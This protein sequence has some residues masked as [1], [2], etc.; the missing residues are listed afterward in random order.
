MGPDRRSTRIAVLGAGAAGLSAAHGVVSKGASVDVYEARDE[1]GGVLRSAQVDATDAKSWTYDVGATSMTLKYTAVAKLVDKLKL[2]PLQRSTDSR[3]TYVVRDGELVPL[4][5]GP[6]AV[7]STPL[8]SVQA[9]LRLFM[10]PFVRKL[11]DSEASRETVDAF[12]KRRF[13]SD[14]AAR[15]VDP[16]VA[17]IYAASPSTLSMRHALPTVW[18]LE[19]EHGSVIRPMIR[20]GGEK[21]PEA[22]KLRAS[23]TFAGGMQ[24]LPRALASV[25]QSRG[26]RLRTG[27][28]VRTLRRRNDGTWQVNSNRQRYDAVVCAIPVYALGGISTNIDGVRNAFARLSSL[29]RYAPMAVTVLGYPRESM[30]KQAFDGIGVLVPTQESRNGILGVQ[31]SSEG[32]PQKSRSEAERDTV[33]VTVY[34]GGIRDPDAV[35]KPSSTIANAAKTEIARL[36]RVDAAPL[37]SAVQTWPHGIPQPGPEQARVQRAIRL[38]ERNVPG[39]VMAG[40]YIDGVGVP[41]AILSG[42]NAAKRAI[43]YVDKLCKITDA[44]HKR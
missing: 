44:V 2:A 31:F 18:R 39:L 28:P 14:L 26:A 16:A 1:V 17:G 19:Q 7:A 41:D 21:D 9:K 15:I 13:S 32:F 11:D 23:V 33:F 37:F 27:Q 38:L 22:K 34:S 6:G 4:P 40:N 5:R 25:L 8:L 30:S 35:S 29:V 42:L 20:R 24:A 10:E 12:F 43:R 3:N 36:L